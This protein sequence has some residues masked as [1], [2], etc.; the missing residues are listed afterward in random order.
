MHHKKHDSH[1]SMMGN[2]DKGPPMQEGAHHFDKGYHSDDMKLEGTE[3]PGDDHYR[4]NNYF[5]LR[6]PV[7]RKDAE[8]LKRSK[9]SKSA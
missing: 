8:K 5:E 3:Y 6:N 1:H 4:G 9:F 2:P 7:V